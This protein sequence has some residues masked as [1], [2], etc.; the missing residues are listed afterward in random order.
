MKMIWTVVSIVGVVTVG[1]LLYMVI[2]SAISLTYSRSHTEALTRKC[3]LLAKLAD[4]GLRGH[5]LEAVI[6]T[7][8]PKVIA[9]VEGSAL[10]L[11]GVVLRIK[12]E[13]IVG[14]DVAETC[15]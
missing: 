4:E 2:D 13:K 15:R 10:R 14:V 11:D 12:N 8:G 1:I 6:R 9:Q 7:A 5:S 3:E